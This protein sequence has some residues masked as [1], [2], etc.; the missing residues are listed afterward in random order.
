MCDKI[1][2]YFCDG[3]AC[4]EDDKAKTSVCFT[5]GGECIR[6]SCEDHSLRKKFGE[7]FPK[8][9]W[10]SFGKDLLVEDIDNYPELLFKALGIIE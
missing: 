10:T 5:K 2:L 4:D 8:T 3:K 6:T 7:N 9:V 1:K